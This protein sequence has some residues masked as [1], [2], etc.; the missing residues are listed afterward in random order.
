MHLFGFAAYSGLIG[1]LIVERSER[2]LLT[3]VIYTVAM[4]LHLLV[5]GHSLS[6]QHGRLY[7][8]RGR[9]LLAVSVLAG[10]GVATNTALPEPVFAH[11]FAVLAGGVVI[12]SLRDELPDD[13][14]GRFWPFCTAALLTALL[15]L[16]SQASQTTSASTIKE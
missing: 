1:Y 2:G 8:E 5:V 10:F 11:L 4:V 14:K 15:L 7:H 16:W 3:L 9:W 6:E 12:T 13:R